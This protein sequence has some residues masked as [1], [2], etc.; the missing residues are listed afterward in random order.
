VISR[1]YNVSPCIYKSIGGIESNSVALCGIF[2]IYNSYVDFILL[3]DAV[4]YAVEK[5]TA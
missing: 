3:L 2:A 1:S 5:V 4:K